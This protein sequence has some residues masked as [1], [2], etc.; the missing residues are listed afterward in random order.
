MMTQGSLFSGIGGFDLGLERAGFKAIWQCEREPFCRA[1]LKTHFKGL[2][3]HDDITKLDPTTL[4]S[5]TVLTGGFPCQDLSIAGQ[6]KGLSASRS[7]LFFEFTR[8]LAGLKPPWFI[9]ENVPGLFSSHEGQDFKIVIETLSNCGYGLAWRILDS[10]FFGVSQRR[11]R[12]FIVGSFGKPCPPEVLFEPTGSKGDSPKGRKAGAEVADTL[13][14]SFA[15]HHGASAGKD[16]IPR[17]HIVINTIRAGAGMPKHAADESK[18]ITTHS[19]NA[20]EEHAVCAPIDPDGVR[21]FAGL[22]LGMDS[23]RY[24]ALGNAVTV[25]VAEWIGK[26][27]HA[28]ILGVCQDE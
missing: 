17:N 18:L 22:P 7:G 1:V 5:P 28:D 6:R 21:D 24:R 12:V 10:Q 14:Q 9:L 26:G 8:I 20:T 23:A 19:L 16:C 25:Q 3:I 15:K 2:S 4:E 27:I 13:T 11:R